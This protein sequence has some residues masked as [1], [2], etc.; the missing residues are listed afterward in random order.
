MILILAS[1]FNLI[2]ARYAHE[3]IGGMTGDTIGALSELTEVITLFSIIILSKI[4]T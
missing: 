4:W 1:A 2:A 3:K